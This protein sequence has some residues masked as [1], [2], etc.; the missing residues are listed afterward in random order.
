MTKPG[1]DE[2]TIERLVIVGASLAGLKAAEAARRSGFQGSVVVIGDEDHLPYDRP[3]LSKQ[4]LH[5]KR[6]VPYFREEDSYTAELNVTLVL[7]RPATAV[8][9]EAKMVIVGDV[10]VPYDS[11]IIATGATP[12]TVPSWTARKGVVTLRRAGDAMTVRDALDAKRDIT[13]AGAG[14]IGAEIASAARKQ[15]CRVTII[16]ATETP[17]ARAL[18]PVMGRTLSE[19][20]TRHGTALH[21]GVTIAEIHGDECVQSV[22]LSDGTTVPTDLLLVSIGAEPNTNWLRGSGMELTSD[23]GI[24]CDEYLESSL[25]GVYAAGDVVHW[26]NEVMDTS[27]RLEHWTSANEQGALAARNATNRG[28]RATYQTVPYFWSDWYGNRIQFAGIA[29]TESPTVVQGTVDADKF[30]ALY[31]D[32]DRL[33]GALTVNDSSRIMKER[34]RIS[35]RTTW[36]EALE[37]YEITQRT[38]VS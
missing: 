12:K 13:I 1:A 10:E 15:G 16:E 32:G 6:D 33:V 7:G 22:T 23:G 27:M 3:P 34:R 29:G 24:V 4:F 31:R 36:E 9:P 17:L 38:P 37:F 26:P 2:T 11:L 14:F 20:H 35:Q 5:D 28:V 18:G 30:V 21:C 19:M 25:P 8:R